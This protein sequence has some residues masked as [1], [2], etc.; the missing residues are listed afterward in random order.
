GDAMSATPDTLD[1]GAERQ[2][3]DAPAA[4]AQPPAGGYPPL[5]GS[6]RTFGTIALSAAVFMNVLDSSIANVSIPTIA[7]DLGVSATQGTWVINSFAVAYAMTVRLTGWLT[8]RFGGVL[9]LV[10]SV[11]IFVVSSCLCGF[12]RS[13]ESLVLLR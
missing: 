10:L 9:Q 5:E 6:A 8:H 1:N 12:A 11:L 2:P 3:D 4:P 13:L 7:G